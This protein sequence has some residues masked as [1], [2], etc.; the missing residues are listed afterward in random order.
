LGLGLRFGVFNALGHRVEPALNPLPGF[1]QNLLRRQRR[2]TQRVPCDADKSLVADAQQPFD[3]RFGSNHPVAKLNGY[4]RLIS[5]EVADLRNNYDLA[6]DPLERRCLCDGRNRERGRFRVHAG[7]GQ[8]EPRRVQRLQPQER[9]PGDGWNV[10]RRDLRAG[11]G[12]PDPLPQPCVEDRVVGPEDA[13]GQDHGH[14]G[15]DQPQ[16]P[17]RGNGGARQLVCQVVR[18]PAGHRIAGPDS[19]F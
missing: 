12:G 10:E 15:P 6:G 11:H 7:A 9:R 8:V 16:S 14:G 13:P 18:D 3:E 5:L 4:R 2:L 17:D 1:G 19:G